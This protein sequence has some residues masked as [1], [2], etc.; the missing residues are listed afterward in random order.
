[1]SLYQIKLTPVSAY[2][3]G[4]EKHFKNRSSS[5]GFEME[6]FANSE[7]Y[8]QQTTL[9]GVLRY[10]LLLKN[11]LLDPAKIDKS[12]EAGNL[13][14]EQSFDFKFTDPNGKTIQEYGKVK[15]ITPLHFVKEDFYFKKESQKYIIA[16]FS[17]GYQLENV[18]GSYRLNGYNAKDGYNK[19]LMNLK[20][21]SVVKLFK[22][23]KDEKDTGFV[24]IPFETVG[25]KKGEKGK[26]EDDGFY[27]LTMYKLNKEWSFA[28]EA[29]IDLDLENEKQ[30]LP[31]GA[32]KQI[33][34][35]EIKKIETNTNLKL[36][37]YGVFPP[38]IFCI[39]DC[40]VD[41]K[42]WE[43]T[44]FAINENISFRN[45][46][47]KTTSQNYSSFT[48]GYK[49]GQRYNLLKRG[50]VL[51]FENDGKLEDAE[52]LFDNTNAKKTGFNHIQTIKKQ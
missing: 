43:H 31:F 33:F 40:F 29:D 39:S 14:G 49:R 17:N 41:E 52:K 16:P 51:F 24:F 21:F 37:Q 19:T 38:A 11:N 18:F 23:P 5:T 6:Y 35:F 10:Y 8:P 12:K 27:K 34:S 13:I 20:D 4:G 3:F 2:F 9:L 7:L 26:S 42:L 32:E 22:N 47:S 44:A 36:G 48:K 45:L 15:S 46:Q 28:F 25:N 50:S 1:M 30:F